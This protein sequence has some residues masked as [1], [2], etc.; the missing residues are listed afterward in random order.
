MAV[1]SR[2]WHV[3]SASHAGGWPGSPL[4]AGPADRPA[5][6]CR[7]AA[8]R[9]KKTPVGYDDVHAA[10]DDHSRLAYAEILPDGKGITG[11]G[12][13]LRAAAFFRAHGMPRAERLITDNAFAYRNSNNFR[14]AVAALGAKRTAEYIEP[15]GSPALRSARSR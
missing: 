14:A 6:P 11:A 3:D 15:G 9:H 5:R 13:L 10:V 1:R 8:Q 2:M 7:V 12:F 4:K